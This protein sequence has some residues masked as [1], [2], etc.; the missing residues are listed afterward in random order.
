MLALLDFVS[1]LNSTSS[2]I[3]IKLSTLETYDVGYCVHISRG[4]AGRLEHAGRPRVLLRM[5]TCAASG[6][7]RFHPTAA[8]DDSDRGNTS[9]GDMFGDQFCEQPQFAVFR[10]LNMNGVPNTSG[11]G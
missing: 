7:L 2:S 11:G 9:A 5:N 6:R 4:M 1:R 10:D 8:K 3:R